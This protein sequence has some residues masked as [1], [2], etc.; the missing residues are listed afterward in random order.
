MVDIPNGNLSCFGEPYTFGQFAHKCAEER[1]PFFSSNNPKGFLNLSSMPSKNLLAEYLYYLFRN[2]MIETIRLLAG[3]VLI[4]FQMLLRNLDDRILPQPILPQSIRPILEV[5]NMTTR[6]I[7]QEIQDED[8]FVNAIMFT[9]QTEWLFSIDEVVFPLYMDLFLWTITRINELF[10]HGMFRLS[11]DFLI[12]FLTSFFKFGDGDN[13][14]EFCRM[15]NSVYLLLFKIA[16]VLGL[17]KKRI[18]YKIVTSFCFRSR[19]KVTIFLCENIFQLHLLFSPDVLGNLIVDIIKNHRM[20][21]D[22]YENLPYICTLET[23]TNAQI[24]KIIHEINDSNFVM[25]DPFDESDE[26]TLIDTYVDILFVRLFGNRLLPRTPDEYMSAVKEYVYQRLVSHDLVGDQFIWRF[27]QIKDAFNKHCVM[28][29]AV[30]IWHGGAQS[31]FYTHFMGVD[32]MKD[33][34]HLTR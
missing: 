31:L 7:L 8:T 28:T 30:G 18:A 2:R 9:F 27:E 5:L 1:I 24:R 25:F 32:S 29:A 26:L 13:E 33:I 11:I 17:D 10:D 21:D 20:H 4:P 14:P 6:R 23:G 34:M 19:V 12:D 22:F 3:E 15:I 16:D